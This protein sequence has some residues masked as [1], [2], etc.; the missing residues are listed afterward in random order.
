MDAAL[1]RASLAAMGRY[2]ATRGRRL[3]RYEDMVERVAS[4]SAGGWAFVHLFSPVD[5]LL[6]PISRGRLSVAFGAPVGVLESR[7]ARTGRRHRTPVL[8]QLMDVDLLLVASNVGRRRHPA[9]LHNVRAHPE[10]RFLTRERGWSAYRARE[11]IG[12]ERTRLW[13]R[14]TDFYAGY[15]AYQERTGQ[16]EIALVVLEADRQAGVEIPPAM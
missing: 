6:L 13:L 10:V 4:S 3:T 5:R 11:A 9:W 15:A 14:A 2:S 12:A 1:V 16:R 8:Y 7:G